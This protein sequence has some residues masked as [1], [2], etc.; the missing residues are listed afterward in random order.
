[1]DILKIDHKPFSSKHKRIDLSDFE[2][3]DF[4]FIN[5]RLGKFVISNNKNEIVYEYVIDL[6][7]FEIICVI[8]D[9]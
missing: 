9:V 8:F 6:K 3:G 4:E 2:E 1:M 7:K 5:K